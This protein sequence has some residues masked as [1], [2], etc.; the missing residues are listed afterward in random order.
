[1]RS[2]STPNPHPPAPHWP[3]RPTT[4]K[5]KP[6]PPHITTP[7]SMRYGRVPLFILSGCC[8]C[9]ATFPDCRWSTNPSVLRLQPRHPHVVFPFLIFWFLGFRTISL[10]HSELTE[11]LTQGS[12]SLSWGLSEDRTVRPGPLKGRA[13]WHT[14]FLSFTQEFWFLVFGLLCR[15]TA[16][17]SITTG[18]HTRG[19]Q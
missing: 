14:F 5:L 15:H 4:T 7:P 2:V 8:W 1:M 11:S 10:G 13:Y 19:A 18:M 17:N 9:A 16:R 6:H 12:S 3:T